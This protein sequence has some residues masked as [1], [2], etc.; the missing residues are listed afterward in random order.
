MNVPTRITK[1]FVL[2]NNIGGGECKKVTSPYFVLG[3][4][5]NNDEYELTKSPPY[6]TIKVNNADRREPTF[7][8]KLGDV[9]ECNN[10]LF[11]LFP[12]N[13][14]GVSSGT[15]VR[16]DFNFVERFVSKIEGIIPLE[17]ILKLIEGLSCLEINLKV[18][19][20]LSLE[21]EF[22]SN[23]VKSINSKLVE[24]LNGQSFRRNDNASDSRRVDI[25]LDD[26][27]NDD[28]NNLDDNNNP[29]NSH[30]DDDDDGTDIDEIFVEDTE[31]GLENIPDSDPSSVIHVGTRS[32]SARRSTSM[33]VSTST[34]V[35][36]ESERSRNSS[37]GKEYEQSE[38]SDNESIDAVRLNEPPLSSNFSPESP[39]S[40]IPSQTSSFYPTPDD[41]SSNQSSQESSPSL[42]IF[43][44][45][46][47]Q[48]R[49]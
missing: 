28:N 16:G 20:S 22:I 10:L 42:S 21:E 7:T 46:K 43:V 1:V 23:V 13:F 30:C 19:Y 29:S 40:R 48:K 47:K 36:N 27:D 24:R 37:S 31:A 3:E 25:D 17:M 26:D 6:R 2:C 32:M 15:D 33:P 39:L 12:K 14:D 45:P 18:G 11:I 8:V 44:P 34:S 49:F 35:G 4:S 5:G 9:I 41:L 38:P